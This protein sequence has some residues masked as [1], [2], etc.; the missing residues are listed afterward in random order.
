MENIKE[1]GV[2]QK[3]KKGDGTFEFLEVNKYR[4]K[5]KD[6]DEDED[7]LDLIVGNTL[8]IKTTDNKNINLD[9]VPVAQMMPL[10]GTDF[11]VD[12]HITCQT[13]AL[14]E[15]NGR[16]N[17][18][19][20]DKYNIMSN[21]FL[22][23]TYS[24][25]LYEDCYNFDQDYSNFILNLYGINDISIDSIPRTFNED[26]LDYNKINSKI[27][28]P[29]DILT[30]MKKALMND[31]EDIKTIEEKALIERLQ[32][33][34]QTD[35]SF[36]QKYFKNLNPNEKQTM[37]DFIFAQNN[38]KFMYTFNKIV[39]LL[40][41]LAHESQEIETFASLLPEEIR[42][43]LEEKDQTKRNNL[44]TNLSSD[45]WQ[46]G[47][48]IGFLEQRTFT[49]ENDI[50][51]DLNEYGQDYTV[52]LKE[53]LEAYLAME[54]LD[55]DFNDTQRF[56][57][58]LM[59]YTLKD[60]ICIYDVN[61]KPQLY[62]LAKG[63][64][65]NN[66]I[67]VDILLQT[68][69]LHYKDNQDLKEPIKKAVI[70][71]RNYFHDPDEE[72]NKFGKIIS[73][74][75]YDET[76][77]DMNAY[78]QEVIYTHFNNC[79]EQQHLT[80][81]A[82]DQISNLTKEVYDLVTNPASEKPAYYNIYKEREN[83]PLTNGYIKDKVL[84]VPTSF[85]PY[86][87]KATQT[88]DKGIKSK[89]NHK[90]NFDDQYI[91][92]VQNL[93]PEAFSPK[94]QFYAKEMSKHL[95]EY[96][97]PN[98]LIKLAMCDGKPETIK[99]IISKINSD[100][101]FANVYCLSN[102]NTEKNDILTAIYRQAKYDYYK[103]I[104]EYLATGIMP[105]KIK[106]VNINYR[107]PDFHHFKTIANN[108][109]EYHQKF[110]QRM[111]YT[112]VNDIKGT[113]LSDI[114]RNIM[115]FIL[116][117]SKPQDG[118][119]IDWFGS[120]PT[121]DKNQTPDNKI[122]C[123]LECLKI[124]FPD[125]EEQFPKNGYKYYKSKDGAFNSL[126][127]NLYEQFNKDFDAYIDECKSNS[128]LDGVKL[129]L[130]YN[131]ATFE[132]DRD[133]YNISVIQRT[134]K[135][136]WSYKH[137]FDTYAPIDKEEIEREYN[138]TLNKSSNTVEIPQSET[139]QEP[140][141]QETSSTIKKESESEDESEYENSTTDNPTTEQA[142][143]DPKY[144]IPNV[145]IQ[146]N[147][148]YAQTSTKQEKSKGL[149]PKIKAALW[150]GLAVLIAAASVALAIPTGGGSLFGLKLSSIAAGLGVSTTAATVIG[151]SGAVV[152]IGSA[153]AAGYFGG[154]KNVK[155][156]KDG[157]DKL[158]DSTVNDK[159][160]KQPKE[161]KTEEEVVCAGPRSCLTERLPSLF[162]RSA[163]TDKGAKQNK[164]SDLNIDRTI[165]S[166]KSSDER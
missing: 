140:K 96:V 144:S 141:P 53:Q 105:N 51:D 67:F 86:N 7:E 104:D 106:L 63:I 42:N 142:E 73:S 91:F 133:E 79:I 149:S 6:E 160:N 55:D 152:G 166:K 130:H 1:I 78:L 48:L 137:L 124:I 28:K 94:T 71:I 157:Y 23:Y 132:F 68:I 37:I 165:I 72:N 57:E 112:L 39:S 111:K 121:T 109:Q 69:M 10:T 98:Y 45:N 58:Y 92:L 14:L 116:Q 29:D 82:K 41:I 100:N 38:N 43:I 119:Y 150:F 12:K 33:K 62:N 64:D 31:N 135:E 101:T 87:S 115:N 93:N 60:K 36:R 40:Q 129:K 76:K 77:Y 89:D 26:E 19:K 15:K 2:K 66:L 126:L 32:T 136:F 154:Y 156:V 102:V 90:L 139:N 70:E 54:Y 125:I 131:G 151:A 34:I 99:D 56:Y 83:V 61:N 52:T 145:R 164:E 107:I 25:S 84:Y 17:S 122:Y 127:K 85:F 117:P 16:E 146:S 148:D 75:H 13:L 27:P 161:P 18:S 80:Q 159:N 49:S 147:A 46:L 138:D 162:D 21:S 47:D 163:A 158:P 50:A 11:C 118:N 120:I 114:C 143:T 123:L 30:Q 4:E 113:Y 8:E 9:V 65:E 22:N 59:Q 108:E 153:V 20:S 74:T 5:M 110:K 134:L 88:I 81:G 3:V 97:I 103:F 24:I 95:N 44:L 128:S 155:L 35:D